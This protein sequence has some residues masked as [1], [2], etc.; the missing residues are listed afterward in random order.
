MSEST[1]DTIKRMIEESKKF[2]AGILQ[3]TFESDGYGIRITVIEP[4]EWKRIQ[5]VE[6][7]VWNGD[8]IV[9]D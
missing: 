4:K 5:A 1:H 7:A 6:D 8:E 2:H 9:E 3:M